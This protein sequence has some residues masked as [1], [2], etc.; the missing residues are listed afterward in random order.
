MTIAVFL[1]TSNGCA[2]GFGDLFYP[3]ERHVD[4]GRNGER[5]VRH[6]FRLIDGIIYFGFIGSICFNTVVIVVVIAV[7]EVIVISTIVGIVNIA[8]GADNG[9]HVST[10]F[11][12]MIQVSFELYEVYLFVGC[13]LV[14]GSSMGD[15]DADVVIGRQS[16][17]GES[18]ASDDS[19]VS[20]A[21]NGD[22]QHH[23]VHHVS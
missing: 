7:I 22:V 5:R 13:V 3:S 11:L 20:T 21:V 2:G 6:F 14:D 19:G 12:D 16:G 17:N 4:I 18:F 1:A 15:H 23:I 8:V 10:A 9:K